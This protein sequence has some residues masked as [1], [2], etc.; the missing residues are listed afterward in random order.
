MNLLIF[1]LLSV[2]P[3]HADMFPGP[4]EGGIIGNGRLVE[5]QNPLMGF[6]VKY[7]RDWHR[8]ALDSMVALSPPSTKKSIVRFSSESL[9]V[10][11]TAELLRFATKKDPQASWSAIIID[12]H[13]GFIARHRD[14]GIIYLLTRS[15]SVLSILFSHAEHELEEDIRAILSSVSISE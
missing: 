2:L 1:I 8:F 10:K 7:P 15:G 5:Y 11:D 6:R 12:G 13:R 14:H 3:L 9:T 4:H